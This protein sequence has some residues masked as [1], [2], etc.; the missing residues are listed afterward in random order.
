MNLLKSGDAMAGT[1][2]WS[3]DAVKMFIAQG[4][5]GCHETWCGQGVNTEIFSPPAEPDLKARSAAG[6]AGKTI[7]NLIRRPIRVAPRHFFSQERGRFGIL[8]EPRNARTKSRGADC[9]RRNFAK[10][11]QYRRGGFS[12]AAPDRNRKPQTPRGEPYRADRQDGLQIGE[13]ERRKG[14]K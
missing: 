13:P 4:L 12:P 5:D 9:A 2:A 10:M 7:G 6:L 1:E 3:R 8:L 11:S 14:H